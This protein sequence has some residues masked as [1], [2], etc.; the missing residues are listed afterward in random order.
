MFDK[1]S[2]KTTYKKKLKSSAKLAYKNLACQFFL[3]QLFCVSISRQFFMI[4]IDT[5]CTSSIW[6]MKFYNI[7]PL[8]GNSLRQNRIPHQYGYYIQ[9]Q[10][11][12][13]GHFNQHK[14]L[15]KIGQKRVLGAISF[16]CEIEYMFEHPKPFFTKRRKV[17]AKY[18]KTCNKFV[19][20]Y[21]LSHKHDVQQELSQNNLKN[22]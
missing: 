6:R 4:T 18:L 10:K 5:V 21:S 19:L 11:Y 15:P 3:Q 20:F 1:I 22:N 8:L 12:K 7:H 2:F 9:T 13:D 16:I 14:Q 17:D